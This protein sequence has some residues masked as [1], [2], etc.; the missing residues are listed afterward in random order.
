MRTKT[1]MLTNDEGERKAVVERIANKKQKNDH[2]RRRER[3]IDR[4]LWECFQCG[5][6]VQESIYNPFFSY[7]LVLLSQYQVKILIKTT[8]YGSF[9]LCIWIYAVFLLSEPIHWQEQ[10]YVFSSAALLSTLVS[11]RGRLTF[12][13]GVTSLLDWGKQPCPITRITVHITLASVPMNGK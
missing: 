4:R 8:C 12:S 2:V 6:R 7:K 13:S 1:D 10:H 5:K 11:P 9:R 3:Q